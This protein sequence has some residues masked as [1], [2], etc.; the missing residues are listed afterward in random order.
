MPASRS[1]LEGAQCGLALRRAALFRPGGEPRH[2]KK[3]QRFVK[4]LR[5]DRGACFELAHMA[6]GQRRQP[7]R[8]HAALEMCA[9]PHGR[10]RVGRARRK[11]RMPPAAVA[12]PAA[13]A[14]VGWRNED[15]M[16]PGRAWHG[17]DRHSARLVRYLVQLKC[18]GAVAIGGLRMR[19]ARLGNA[20][21]GVARRA[22]PVG[23]RHVAE[24]ED[25]DQTLLMIEH[26]QA[27]HL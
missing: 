25:A 19:A 22:R 9:R 20:A 8:R 10:D 26:R 11:Q 17:P 1:S 7:R 3:L 6:V 5:I 24:R 27:A 2:L 21:Q 14:G 18:A 16:R 12:R 23:Q 15:R 4:F 13:D